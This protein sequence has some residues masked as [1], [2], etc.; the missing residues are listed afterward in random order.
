VTKQKDEIR[1]YERANMTNFEDDNSARIKCSMNLIHG[2][3]SI[4]DVIDVS[5]CSY[6]LTVIW[7]I[8]YNKLKPLKITRETGR[9]N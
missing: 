1:S 4:A 6:I 3:N 5:E 9:E 7:S 2:K 8:V